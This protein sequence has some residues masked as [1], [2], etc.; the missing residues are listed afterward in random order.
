M[1]TSLGTALG[2][3]EESLE[4]PALRESYQVVRTEFLENSVVLVLINFPLVVNPVAAEK[5]EMLKLTN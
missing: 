3:S 1:L 5:T 2:C 4:P